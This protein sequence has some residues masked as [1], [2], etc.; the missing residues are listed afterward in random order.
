M[1]CRKYH[2]YIIN[3]IRAALRMRINKD[4]SASCA[5]FFYYLCDDN[6]I[7]Y[8]TR[9]SISSLFKMSVNVS[10]RNCFEELLL[11][12][13][14]FMF[15]WTSTYTIY[16]LHHNMVISFIRKWRL[17]QLICPR[18][19]LTWENWTFYIYIMKSNM[20]LRPS[21]YVCQNHHLLTILFYSIQ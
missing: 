4:N 21:V 15:I 9:V 6:C 12:E 2:A 7:N 14:P 1:S 19:N 17:I 20:F 11:K 5:I 3:V 18:I 16:L 8:I 13:L 10:V